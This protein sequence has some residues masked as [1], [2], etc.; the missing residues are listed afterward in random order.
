MSSYRFLLFPL[1]FIIISSTKDFAMSL[2]LCWLHMSPLRRAVWHWHRHFSL[3][4]AGFALGRTQGYC[5]Q[6][7]WI[8]PQTST[9]TLWHTQLGMKHG[10]EPGVYMPDGGMHETPR[11]MLDMQRSC[12]EQLVTLCLLPVLPVGKVPWEEQP[13]GGILGMAG[14][15]WSWKNPHYLL[16]FQWTQQWQ[17]EQ[18][19]SN[20]KIQPGCFVEVEGLGQVLPLLLPGHESSCSLGEFFS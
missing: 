5:K 16:H 1:L 6:A 17:L 9:T 11:R 7:A 8:Q 14:S 2:F 3:P 12:S 19:H 20:S 4:P 13:G 15:E 10:A 18:R